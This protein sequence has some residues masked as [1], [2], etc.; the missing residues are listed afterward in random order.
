MTTYCLKVKSML[1]AKSA[2]IRCICCCTEAQAKYFGHTV[3]GKSLCV[4]VLE[5]ENVYN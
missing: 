2:S 4:E 5:D 3:R 1:D